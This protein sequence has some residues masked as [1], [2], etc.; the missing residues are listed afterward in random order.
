MATDSLE[1][2]SS[3]KIGDKISVRYYGWR[4]PIFG[5]FP[6]IVKSRSKCSCS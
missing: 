3:I 4:V 1:D 6:N 2:W 5:L